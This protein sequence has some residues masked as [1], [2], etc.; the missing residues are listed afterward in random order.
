MPGRN[1]SLKF[2]QL[3]VPVSDV[4]SFLQKLSLLERNATNSW[5]SQNPKLNTPAC[6]RFGIRARLAEPRARL[7]IHSCVMLPTIDTWISA[8]AV[9]VDRKKELTQRRMRVAAW[10]NWP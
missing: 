3:Q 8:G 4:S 2:G 9:W 7:A 6:Q 10:D 1:P 5:H